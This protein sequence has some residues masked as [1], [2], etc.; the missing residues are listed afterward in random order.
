MKNKLNITFS[1]LAVAILGIF[2]FQSCTKKLDTAY[3]N[4]HNPVESPLETILPNVINQ[5]TSTAAPPA[6]G[7]GGSYGPA[8]ESVLMA[9][10]IQYWGEV[11]AANAN[12]SYDQ[13]GGVYGTASDNTGLVWAMHYY[14]IGA[15]NMYII[16]R[17][18]EQQK[19]DYVGVAHAIFAYSWLTLTEE[20]GEVILKQAFDGGR[21]QFDYD[22]QSA[23]YDTV[24]KICDAAITYLS[25]TD[26]AVSPTE[27]AKGDGYFLGGDVNKWKKFVYAIKARSFAHLSNKAIYTANGYADSVIKY[28]DLSVQVN[29][30]N[31]MQ[32][33]VGGNFSGTNNYY[34]Q[35]RG[36]IGSIRQGAFIA[37]LLTGANVSS[38]FT[39]VADP[40]TPYLINENTN[41][42][43]KGVLP[44]QGTSGLSTNDQP[45]NFWRAA[46]ASTSTATGDSGRYIFN[47]LAPYPVIT[48][49]DI[50]FM[51]AEAAF[52]KGD[53][54]T[55]LAAYTK[56][57]D[58]SFDLLQ[59]TYEGRIPTV[60]KITPATKAAYMANPKVIP[61]SAAGLTLSHIMLQKYI[62]LYGYGFNETWTDM[63]RYHYTDLDPQT[64]KSVYA[65]FTIPSPLNVYNN[66]K[67]VY[68]AR[69]RYNSEYLYNI[70][71][72]QSIGA[73]ASD[74]HTKEQWFMQP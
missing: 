9:R 29:A 57:I 19:W 1:L 55:A 63:R 39:G 62:A 64:G 70:P 40:R 11:S 33:W 45:K 71:A 68:R 32:K 72:L 44:G 46:F 49:S 73:L 15:N 37:D 28:C 5:M 10:Y 14:G 48:A 43:Y 26:G 7:G 16:S 34:G 13:M 69:P 24:R 47:N 59:S 65:G 54:A 20:Y 17:G 30:D 8:A 50:Q 21:S 35:Y 4:P 56:G 52:R 27:L 25:R 23:V 51:K 6:G 3:L 58:L 12:I 31:A 22:P 60:S 74:Y 66:V 38:P 18:I 2:V 61:A 36:N 41:G 53:K 67:P 42:T